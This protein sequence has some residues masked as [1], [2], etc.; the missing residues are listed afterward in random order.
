MYGSEV[1]S[2][3]LISSTI[4]ATEAKIAIASMTWKL[5]NQ[6]VFIDAGLSIPKAAI[7]AFQHCRCFAIIDWTHMKIRRSMTPPG[8]T[9]L[10]ENSETLPLA[11]SS[12]PSESKK[13]WIYS[14][15]AMR[16]FFMDFE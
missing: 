3:Q 12:V 7:N 14:L 10:D 9:R 16:W 8:M 1:N 2:F 13:R 5:V 6:N 11:M 15:R 4:E